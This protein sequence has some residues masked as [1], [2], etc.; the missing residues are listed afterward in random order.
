[1]TMSTTGAVTGTITEGVTKFPFV[2]KLS[3]DPASLA[4]LYFKVALPKTDKSLEII[5]DHP[6]AVFTGTLS[7]SASP[8]IPEAE[9]K[10]LRKV[11]TATRTAASY[12]GRHNYAISTPTRTKARRALALAATPS[13]AA[14]AASSEPES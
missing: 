2:T 1:M 3:L 9:V 13:L 7:H 14:Q 8:E 12:A 10:G 11:W 6:N 4:S 5:F